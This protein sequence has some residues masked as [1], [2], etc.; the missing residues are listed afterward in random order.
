MD[1]LQVLSKLKKGAFDVAEKVLGVTRQRVQEHE[2]VAV[3]EATDD[4]WKYDARCAAAA[5]V[6]AQVPDA[7]VVNLLQKYFCLDAHESAAALGEG[8]LIVGRKKYIEKMRTKSARPAKKS[9]RK[10]T[11]VSRI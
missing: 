11:P 1:K 7:D 5:L 2:D 4:S 10:I 6:D 9:P 3:R 8:R